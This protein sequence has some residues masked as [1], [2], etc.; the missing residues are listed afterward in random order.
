MN[1]GPFPRG[2]ANTQETPGRLWGKR[3]S[4]AGDRRGEVSSD[5]G[6]FV[7]TNTARARGPSRRPI[8]T[9]QPSRME[10]LATPR[11]APTLMRP[12]VARRERES[13][14]PSGR[15][16]LLRVEGP[17]GLGGLGGVPLEPG[18]PPIGECGCRRLVPP[19]PA[20]ASAAGGRGRDPGGP[21]PRE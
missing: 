8:R 6:V 9:V 12:C 10:G 2:D 18:V 16:S 4:I 5:S 21:P 14:S 15:E 20:P 1:A 11:L 17:R 7:S 3:N 19:S 13:R